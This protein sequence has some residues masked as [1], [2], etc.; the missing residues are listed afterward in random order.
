MDYN[1]FAEKFKA[2]NPDYADRDNKTLAEALIKKHPYYADKVT[3]EATPAEFEKVP[4]MKPGEYPP[5]SYTTFAPSVNLAMLAQGAGQLA[6]SAPDIAEA[7]GNLPSAIKGL[8]PTPSLKA[9]GA[10]A[11]QVGTP[12]AQ[13]LAQA[14]RAYGAT[15]Q[16][17]IGQ[18]VAKAGQTAE[19]GLSTSPAQASIFEKPIIEG[20]V[21]KPTEMLGLVTEHNK[22][23]GEAIGNT[24]EGLDKSGTKFD[25]KPIIDKAKSMLEKDAEGNIMT[26][27]AQGDKNSAI[28]EALSSLS[29]YSKGKPINWKDANRIKGMLQD[30]GNY[31]AKRFQ[32]SNEAYKQVASL[33]KEGIDEQ[34]SNVLQQTGGNIQDF[35]N[36][37]N[38][39]GKTAVLKQML[40]HAAGKEL[41][42]PST[43]EAVIGAVKH[44]IPH[45][46]GL[47]AVY[48]TMK[49]L[50]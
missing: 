15:A 16:P 47:T 29:D 14:A 48:E 13:D 18:L 5:E 28:Q 30:S 41:L 46:L 4:G 20:A 37:R 32:E 10:G 12:A 2:Q 22:Q 38:A 23:L 9:L 26:T 42:Q 19:S 7:I 35:Q 11:G 50:F 8:M 3:F 40:T 43:P 27:G 17:E 36:L 39:Y 33:I 25:P 45:A 49:H 21:K 6:K 44:Y 1:E 24:L 34:G 31:A